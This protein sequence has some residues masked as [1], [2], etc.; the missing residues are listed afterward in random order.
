MPLRSAAC[1]LVAALL[2]CRTPLVHAGTS[3]SLLDIS[4]DGA[5]LLVAHPDNGTVTVVDTA[6]RKALREVKVGDKAEGV[7]WIG[8][9]PLAAAA[10]YHENK[11]VVF[12]ADD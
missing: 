9:G 7:S 2:C 4:P 12:S 3:N 10:V 6:A 11:V 5:R 1:L 8:S